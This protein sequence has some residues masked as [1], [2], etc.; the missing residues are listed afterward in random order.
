MKRA[1]VLLACLLIAS[2]T[3]AQ[4]QPQTPPPRDPA[5]GTQ[6]PASKTTPG[7]SQPAAAQPAANQPGAAPSLDTKPFRWRAI[8][9]ANMGGRI[10]DFAVDE[11]NAYTIYAAVGTGGVLKSTN[12]RTTWQ[13]GFDKEAVASTGGVA[14]PP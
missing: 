14:V 6:T 8:G 13:A 5:E 9:P 2:I 4:T 3:S 11:K 10:A 1:T 7:S 12:N